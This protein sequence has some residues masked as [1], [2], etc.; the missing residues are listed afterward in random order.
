MVRLTPQNKTH[1]ECKNHQHHTKQGLNYMQNHKECVIKLTWSYMIL[2]FWGMNIGHPKSAKTRNRVVAWHEHFR[3]LMVLHFNK[4]SK[5]WW[6]A[7]GSVSDES[8]VNPSRVTCS[9]GQFPK[10]NLYVKGMQFP[11]GVK[12]E[13]DAIPHGCFTTWKRT[14]GQ[15]LKDP[16]AVSFLFWI[17]QLLPKSGPMPYPFLLWLPTCETCL[18]GGTLAKTFRKLSS[19]WSADASFGTGARRLAATKIRR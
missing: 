12:C 2:S 5:I 10:K 3:K 9:T 14:L 19:N 16:Q 15:E 17:H 4:Q 11:M 1:V 7:S 8:S 13:G 6:K 18:P